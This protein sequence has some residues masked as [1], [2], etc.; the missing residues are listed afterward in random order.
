MTPDERNF[1]FHRSGPL[2]R[3]WLTNLLDAPTLPYAFAPYDGP[4]AGTFFV[5]GA[6]PSLAKNAHELPRLQREGAVI[7]TVNTALPAVAKH[8]TPDVVLTRELVD[9]SSHLR[10]PARLR[11][12]DLGASPA[13]WDVAREMG[14]CAWYVAGNV[15]TF[16][17][18]RVLGVRPLFG[19]PAALTAMVE[20]CAQ[21]GAAEIV[22]MGA[23]LALAPD[24]AS[25][26]DGSAFSGQR[27]TIGA[28]GM[29]VN[30]GDGFAEKQRQHAAAGLIGHPEREATVEVPGWG[31]VTLRTTTQWL[32]QVEWLETFA[33]QHPDIACIDATE[34]GVVKRGWECGRAEE[35][36]PRD[37][38]T[39]LDPVDLATRWPT[40]VAALRAHLAAEVEVAQ[41]E[42]VNVLHPGGQIH[43]VP[44]LLDGHDMVDCLAAKKLLQVSEA[45]MPAINKIRVS[46]AQGYYEAAEEVRRMMP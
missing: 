34:G 33:E 30:G 13:V 21:W 46:Y 7:C 43:T 4:R 12:L 10:H 2:A 44:S 19:G 28:D 17:L 22:L 3:A 1:T 14:P 29:A 39:W 31:G 45:Q 26:A 37:D 6:G 16:E 23:D 40:D 38:T 35:V 42:A 25:Y 36:E 32:P 11:V 5:V 24:G 20:L 27:A 8:V 15:N 9:V 18:S 41:L